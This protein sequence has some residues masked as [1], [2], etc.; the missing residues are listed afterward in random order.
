[1]PSRLQNQA[2]GLLAVLL[3]V[4]AVP[5]A[6]APV[7]V[8][9]VE[10]ARASRGVTVR[11]G[12]P[13]RGRDTLDI[14]LELYVAQVLSA[15]GEPNAPEAAAQALAIAIRTYALFNTGRHQKEGFDLCDTTHC[16][17]L[18]ASSASSRRAAQATLGQ[19]LTYQGAP[20][21][22]YY[23]ASCGGRTER[24]SDVW[25]KLAL[26]Y[27]DAVDDDVHGEDPSWTMER[28]LDD[29]RDALV[30]AGAKGRRL[31]D[32][33]VESRTASGRAGRVGVPGL[34][35]ASM[36]SNDFRLAVGPT[37]L[38]ST[39]FTITRSGDRVTFTGRG[40]G[41]GVGMCVIGAGRRAA[42]GESAAQILSRYFP[43]LAFEDVSRVRPGIAP[44][45]AASGPA[46]SASP[47]PAAAKPPS[48]LPAPPAPPALA[49][50]SAP[51]ALIT[52]P[53]A[54]SFVRALVPPGSVVQA[55]EL[56]RL[57]GAAQTRMS[58]RL[59]VS[60]PTLTIR[61][62]GTIDDFRRATGQPWWVS[63]VVRGGE[64]DLA[65]AAVL[66]QRDGL[67]RA[68]ERAVAEASV[69]RAFEG[70]HA[71]VR[72]GAARYFTGGERPADGRIRCP[73]DAD[74]TAAV[75]AAAQR[76]AESRAEA[77]FAHA[78]T[79]VSDWRDIR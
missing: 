68:V 46:L 27:L 12:S 79:H 45:E 1:L 51:P 10:L 39:A 35:P 59:G 72:V 28:S 2:L 56:E 8:T 32:V 62:H 23:S 49:A 43:G 15:E 50:P 65:P 48:A 38:R 24:A 6:Q 63:A 66:D 78:M 40:Y 61:L 54:A 4:L 74:L 70:R 13:T 55:T 14:P 16:Q 41:H 44:P 3:L 22:L 31:D 53:K 11:I 26:P 36:N 71:W 17:V 47:A 37:E 77:C 60:V 5:A 19:V 29:I 21:D 69:V 67:A 75:S 18:R 25:P 73:A 7:D 57:A 58:R 34:E 20:A 64:I 42:R 33:V 52:P 9:D 30:R 76:E